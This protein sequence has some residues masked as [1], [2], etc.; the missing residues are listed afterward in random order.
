MSV[1][2]VDT[3]GSYLQPGHYTFTIASVPMKGDWGPGKNY[4][5]FDFMVRVH[6]EVL[7]HKE[8]IPVW[9]VG[10]YLR[11][12]GV[13]ESEPDVFEWDKATSVGATFDAEIILESGKDGKSYRHIKNPVA[14]QG[15]PKVKVAANVA[16][17]EE[18]PF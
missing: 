5:D 2:R 9:L 4:Y 15:F 1:E 13:P 8:K 12:I 14:I 17:D 6:G 16:A 18:P 11:A 7:S 10:P 3:R